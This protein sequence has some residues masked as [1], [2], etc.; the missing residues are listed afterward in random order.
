MLRKLAIVAF[1]ISLAAPTAAAT[2][3]QVRSERDILKDV[4]R[5]VTTYSRFT[6]FDDINA[7]YED[8]VITL[9][10]EVTQPFKRD[11]IVRRV[12]GVPG[13]LKVVDKIQ[14]LPLSP[15]DDALRYRIARAI[16]GNPSFWTYASMPNPPIH[17][18]VDEGH[19]T[20][21][22]VVNSNVDRMLAMSIASSFNAFSVKND[23]RTDKEAALEREYGV[24]K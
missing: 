2:Q 3:S 22:G 4:V 9:T 14:V 15:F 5:Q 24:V 7:S 1:V 19:V 16:Y 18:V 21:T 12:A 13:I 11:D 20:L 17:I 23:L 8:G 6:V 10:G